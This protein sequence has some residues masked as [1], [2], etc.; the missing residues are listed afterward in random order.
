MKPPVDLRALREGLGESRRE[1]AP[2]LMISEATLE[3]W[4]RGQGG[5]RIQHMGV[6]KRLQAKLHAAHAATYFRYDGAAEEL[7]GE[8]L[9]EREVIIRA[10]APVGYKKLEEQVLSDQ[11]W[12][13]AFSVPWLSRDEGSALLICTGAERAQWPLVDFTL[14]FPETNATALST[15][16]AT[17]CYNHGLATDML[18]G[19]HGGNRLCVRLRVFCTVLD[20]ETIMHVHGNLQSWWNRFCPHKGPDKI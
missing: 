16:Q 2:K 7:P 5:P 19:A 20:D 18:P 12:K 17:A 8:D 15:E 6:L 1:F 3:R 10:L 14:Q 9:N 13:L 11:S 4:E